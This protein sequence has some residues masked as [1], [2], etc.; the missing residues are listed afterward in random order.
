MRAK[1][2]SLLA[3]AVTVAAPVFATAQDRYFGPEVGI[4]FPSNAAMRAALGDEWI[5]FG[6]STMTTG[7]FRGTPIGTNWNAVSQSRNGNTVFIASYSLGT[8]QFLGDNRGRASGGLQP[9][10]A[11]R[12]GVSY[13]DYAIGSGLNRTSAK[14]V[15]YNANAE[16]G[17]Q[18]TQQFVVS[19]RYDIYSRYDG[20]TFDGLTLNLRYGLVRF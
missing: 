4:F 17:V 18:I 10:V 20:F 2:L 3:V 14:R 1:A 7:S 15:G 5:S 19:A 11:L 8:M 16:F 6:A 13:I 12:A 9:F